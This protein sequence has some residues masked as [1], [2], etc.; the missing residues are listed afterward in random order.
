MNYPHKKKTTISNEKSITFGKRGMSFED[1]LNRSNEYYLATNRAVIH[2]KPT[3]VQIVKVNYPKRAAAVITEAYFRTPST[4]DFNGIFKGH[5]ID[6]EAKETS[7]A[8]IFPLQ[9]LHPHQVQHMS[10]VAKHGGITFLL[11]KFSK[12]N[13]IYLLPSEKLTEFWQQY[14]LGNRR[15]IRREEFQE[16]GTLIPEGAYPRIDYL[17]LVDK[18]YL[19]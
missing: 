6:F 2:K 9:N 3:P 16:Y 7:N 13:E 15:S 14:R 17:S 18:L 4:T 1:D 10:Q 8:T 12:F 19:S 11:V 5:Y